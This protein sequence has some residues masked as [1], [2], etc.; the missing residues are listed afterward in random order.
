MWSCIES[1]TKR[2]RPIESVSCGSVSIGTVAQEEGGRVVL[3]LV[4]RQEQRQAS[5]D[6]EP[7]DGEVARVVGE[8]AA[9]LVPEVAALV[10]DAERRALEDRE[11][12]GG[13][14]SIGS[15]A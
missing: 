12:H 7:E 15:V 6:R 4:R 9:G 14:L 11:R 8:E 3:D 5:F 1:P 13:R 10:A 2:E